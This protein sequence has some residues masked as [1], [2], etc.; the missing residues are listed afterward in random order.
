M[1]P[2]TFIQ[3]HFSI[4]LCHIFQYAVCELSYYTKRSTTLQTKPFLKH[5]S[6]MIK[7]YVYSVIKNTGSHEYK[8]HVSIIID[9]LFLPVQPWVC[10]FL[11]L[12]RGDSHDTVRPFQG[13]YMC[14]YNCNTILLG[15]WHS[16]TDGTETAH[17]KE[18]FSCREC[19]LR[20][21]FT[22]LTLPQSRDALW[23]HSSTIHNSGL[24]FIF[25]A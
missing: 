13:F 24:I 20:Y 18:T 10:Q 25:Q 4:E 11:W 1:F 21:I 16:T 9:I 6:F 15:H 8:L 7:N 22:P 14:H 12:W 3:I 5:F 2:C 17:N 23:Q 19:P